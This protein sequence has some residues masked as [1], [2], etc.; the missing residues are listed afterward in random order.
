MDRQQKL[1]SSLCLQF[2]KVGPLAKRV[3]VTGLST[4]SR[5]QRTEKQ[6]SNWNF[7]DLTKWGV[8][9]SQRI[10]HRSF[11]YLTNPC[12]R[13]VTVL[14]GTLAK[15]KATNTPYFPLGTGPMPEIL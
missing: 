4:E 7:I 13:G 6:P 9:R 8:C 10:F 11:Q 2:G 12:V 14:K 15:L 3:W 1:C 5:Q